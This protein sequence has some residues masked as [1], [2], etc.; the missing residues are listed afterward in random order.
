MAASGAMHHIHH[1]THSG[2]TT[3]S[4]DVTVDTDE[5]SAE[6]LLRAVDDPTPARELDR[7]SPVLED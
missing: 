1:V 4:I 7:T 5:A 3:E 2:R 6:P